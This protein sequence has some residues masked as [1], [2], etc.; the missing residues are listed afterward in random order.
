MQMSGATQGN[1]VWEQKLIQKKID[2]DI[3]LDVWVEYWI[4]F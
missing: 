4:A 2:I 3:D 1:L